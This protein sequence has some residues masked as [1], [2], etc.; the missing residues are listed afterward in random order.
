MPSDSWSAGPREPE[1]KP[2][3]DFDDIVTYAIGLFFAGGF[4]PILIALVFGVSCIAEAI[5]GPSRPA[6]VYAPAYPG[7]GFAENPAPGDDGSL[8]CGSSGPVYVGGSDPMGLDGDGDGWGC[9][10]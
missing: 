6:P 2:G 3:I 7:S 1:P 10:S 8:D 5:D 4:I 9:E